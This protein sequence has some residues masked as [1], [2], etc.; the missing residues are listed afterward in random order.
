MKNPSGTLRNTIEI[1]DFAEQQLLSHLKLHPSRP[2]GFFIKSKANLEANAYDRTLC[3]IDLET[4][5]IE[6]LKIGATPDDFFLDH[7]ESLFLYREGSQSRVYAFDTEKRETQFITEVQGNIHDLASHGG[8]FYYLKKSRINR[9]AAWEMKDQ[10][11]WQ[12]EEKIGLYRWNRK[13]SQE[14]CLLPEN[15]IIDHLF[16][17]LP[18]GLIVFNAFEEGPI[19]PVKSCL[20]TYSLKTEAIQQW[21]FDN[22]RI[23]LVANLDPDHL[24]YM[25][26]DLNVKSRNDNLTY[27]LINKNTKCKVPV[28]EA[29][30]C[31]IG[32]PAIV[33]DHRFGVREYCLVKDNCLYHVCVEREREVLR[34]FKAPRL[35]LDQRQE[36]T[37]AESQ[38]SVITQVLENPLTLIN[39]FALWQDNIVLIGCLKGAMQEVFQLKEE[40]LQALTAYHQDYNRRL[41]QIEPC[42]GAIDGWVIRP[43]GFEAGKK[44]PGILFIHGGPKMIY[45]QAYNH[46]MEVLAGKG[47]FIL[48]ANP[49][50]S[51][52]RG[53]EFSNIRGQFGEKAYQELMAFVTEACKTYPEIDENRLGVTGG[54]YGGYMT[55]YI[56]TKT[57]RFKGAVSE[58]GICDLTSAF[59]TSDIGYQYVGEYM[60]NGPSPWEAPDLYREASP[61][62]K[63]Y[64]VKTPTLFNHGLADIRCHPSESLMMHRGLVFHGTLSELCLYEGEGHGFVGG[65]KPQNRLKRYEKVVAWF[66]RFLKQES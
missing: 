62:H 4:L 65:G 37:Q 11:S 12:A 40:G 41:S 1:E 58:R 28:H 44:Y 34:R 29:P 50:G 47:Y 7:E 55:N 56:I 15:L 31:S 46:D 17:D 26:V 60:G 30:T 57:Q 2:Y 45:S 35:G 16:F 24:V 33:S 25:A 14:T 23:E 19:R 6:D 9:E 42:P 21:T 36:Q 51:D 10:Q 66:E 48:F 18:S 39:D 13:K 61:I 3:Q 54:S 49:S 8:D 53:D 27:Y 20:Y 63:A 64:L 52:G 59:L 43:K 38:C 5:E 32:R 22:E